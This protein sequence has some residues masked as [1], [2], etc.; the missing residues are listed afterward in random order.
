[1]IDVVGA[2]DGPCELLEKVIVF[3]CTL[4]RGNGRKMFSFIA[5]E[6]LGHQIQ[7]LI[8]IRFDKFTV[9]LYKWRCQALRVVNEPEAESPLDAKPASTGMVIHIPSRTDDLII[10]HP[11]KQATSTATIGTDRFYL[12]RWS[13]GSFF[14]QRSN[15]TPDYAFST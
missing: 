4:G 3:V 7:S 8:P 5:G 14:G 11:Q 10:T 6:F 1:V 2:H 12:V 15:R 9:A 13:L